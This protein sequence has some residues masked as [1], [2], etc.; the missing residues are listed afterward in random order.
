MAVKQKDNHI[1]LQIC[2]HFVQL[3]YERDKDYPSLYELR[4]DLDNA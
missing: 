4:G 2:T 3:R 1:I